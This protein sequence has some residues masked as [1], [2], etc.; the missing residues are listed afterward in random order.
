ATARKSG[1]SLKREDS[2]PSLL[3]RSPCVTPPDPPLQRGREYR[4]VCIAQLMGYSP[5]ATSPSAPAACRQASRWRDR[6]E[7]GLCRPW[8][9]PTR[10]DR[11]EPVLSRARLDPGWAIRRRR[12]EKRCPESGLPGAAPAANDPRTGACARPLRAENVSGRF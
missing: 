8:R 4:D 6:S 2:T 10:N 12:Y 9:P 11:V 7:S 1:S 3:S 5:L